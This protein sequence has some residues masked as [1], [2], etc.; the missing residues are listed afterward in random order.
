MIWVAG[1]P[2][3]SLAL[4]LPK[5]GSALGSD[6]ADQ[7]FAQLGHRNSQGWRLYSW[8]GLGCCQALD[9]KRSSAQMLS[10]SVQALEIKNINRETGMVPLGD[11][12]PRS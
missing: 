9:L 7:G 4:P 1:K 11:K 6:Q 5:A 2:G 12:G 3:S 10:E 8:V